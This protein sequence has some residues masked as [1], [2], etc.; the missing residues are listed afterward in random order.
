MRGLVCLAIVLLAFA[1]NGSGERKLMGVGSTNTLPLAWS[2][3]G[4]RLAVETGGLFVVDVATGDKRKLS[5]NAPYPPAWSPDGTQ[6]AFTF[7]EGDGLSQ[8]PAVYVVN[9]D[10]SGQPRKLTEGGG[11]SWSPDG[12]SIA[13]A[14]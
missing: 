9:A 2:P 8:S 6:L 13:F 14:K 3:D 4:S 10:G 1:C 7:W 11:P 5:E 12:L